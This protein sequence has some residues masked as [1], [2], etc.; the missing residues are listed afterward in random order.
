[1]E[2]ALNEDLARIETDEDGTIDIILRTEEGVFEVSVSR[3]DS[4]TEAISCALDT[5]PLHQ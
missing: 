1:M 4:V 2:A 3:A 5:G